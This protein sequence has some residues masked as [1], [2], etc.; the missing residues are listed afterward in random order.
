M[1]STNASDGVNAHPELL[2]TMNADRAKF[3]Q[4]AGNSVEVQMAAM[5]AKCDEHFAY[6]Q[7]ALRDQ[8]KA[9]R[10]EL[11]DSCF[12]YKHSRYC[13]GMVLNTYWYWCKHSNSKVKNDPK[14]RETFD[15]LCDILGVERRTG[16][17][18]LE[19]YRLA[20]ELPEEMKEAAANLNIDLGERRFAPLV[21]ELLL[22]K[23]DVKHAADRKQEAVRIVEAEKK[24]FDAPPSPKSPP[25]R[26]EQL[27]DFLFSLYGG[28]VT[29]KE[30]REET[31][32]VLTKITWYARDENAMPT[33]REYEKEQKAKAAKQAE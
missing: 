26:D 25:S 22:Q 5:S 15:G 1:E 16:Y 32:R 2:S 30:F 23:D 7:P 18:I 4:W 19:A 9:L 8:E 3:A 21:R 27:W 24:N 14:Q 6:L 28:K 10:H 29:W 11:I 17:Y 13:F 31:D 20:S 33:K 12:G